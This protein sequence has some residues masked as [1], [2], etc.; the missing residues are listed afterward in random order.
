METNNRKIAYQQKWDMIS[1][2]ASLACAVHCVLLPVLF[3]TLPL[4]GMEILEN[5]YLEVFTILVS[6]FVGGRALWRGYRL[7]H[8]RKSLLYVFLVGMLL[9]VSGNLLHGSLVEVGFKLGG[10]VLVVWAHVKNWQ[11][12]RDGGTCKTVS[13]SGRQ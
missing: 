11:Y 6:L 10:A 5:I 3:T 8:G 13:I 9:M 7:H 1:I 2:G 4:F 12:G